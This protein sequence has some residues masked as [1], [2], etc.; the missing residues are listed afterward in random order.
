M[1]LKVVAV[2]VADLGEVGAAGALAALDPVAGDPA[3]S[4]EAV[5]PRLTW[6]EPA[7]VAVKPVGADGGEVSAATGRL[8]LVLAF[9]PLLSVA[10]RMIS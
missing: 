7:A 9:S 6:L 5:Q 3:L 4:V 1:S 8:T 2:G 10:V